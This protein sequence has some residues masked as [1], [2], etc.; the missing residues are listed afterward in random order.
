MLVADSAG[1]EASLGGNNML[2]IYIQ[3]KEKTW[4]DKHTKGK[5]YE[6]HREGRKTKIQKSQQCCVF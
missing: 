2:E 3:Q 5:V 4:S 6:T 1:A